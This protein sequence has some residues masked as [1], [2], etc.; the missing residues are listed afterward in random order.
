MAWHVNTQY[1][2]MHRVLNHRA[3][4]RWLSAMQVRDAKKEVGGG[5]DC[6]KWTKFMCYSRS[7][8]QSQSH[9]LIYSNT[10]YLD[11]NSKR[12][13]VREK[14]PFRPAKSLF[15]PENSLFRPQKSDFQHEKPTFQPKKDNFSV[16]IFLLGIGRGLLIYFSEK[17]LL[18]WWEAFAE[19]LGIF[20]GP[21][22]RLFSS[23]SR[24]FSQKGYLF[25]VH[26]SFRNRPRFINLIYFFEKFLLP[27]WE[28]FA[29]KLAIFGWQLSRRPSLLISWAL[30]DEQYTPHCREYR[31]P[32]QLCRI[33][34]RIRREKFFVAF[35]TPCDEYHHAF[36]LMLDEAGL[37]SYK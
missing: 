10:G 17:F 28:D 31:W 27:W 24:L 19:K 4:G 6:R 14:V 13:C 30:C 36:Y 21:K 32:D 3:E 15:R 9:K 22:S 29:E 5:Q 26:L 1:G 37:T 16:S 2:A 25:S 8:H 12:R 7:P 33:V 20:C 35:I 11:W 23:K 34:L 18:P